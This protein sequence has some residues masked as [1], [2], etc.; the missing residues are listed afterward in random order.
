MWPKKSVFWAEIVRDKGVKKISLIASLGNKHN[1]ED[2][3][4]RFDN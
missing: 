2:T 1:Q 3:L 4:H